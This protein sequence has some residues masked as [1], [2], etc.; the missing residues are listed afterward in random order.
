M[1]DYFC[2]T[3]AMRIDL[4]QL[5][6]S[7]SIQINLDKLILQDKTLT[8]AQI[9]NEDI[10]NINVRSFAANE[11][12]LENIIANKVKLENTNFTDVL[13]I[14]SELTAAAMS[15]ASWRRVQIKTSRCGGLQLQASDLKDVTFTGCKL[16]LVNF[17]QSKLTNV[18]FEDCILDEADFNAAELKNVYFH[19][20]LLDKAEFSNSKLSKVD[21]R[22][23]DINR[24]LGISSFAGAIIDS[25]QLTSIAPVLASE[26]N[27]DVRD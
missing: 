6:V 5:S 24:V 26:L 25:L 3:S 22:T 9:K 1:F 8:S 20:C 16:N 4:P 21:F 10:T 19:K 18:A 12:R 15:D 2:Y 13:I 23:S 17:R 27:I 14:D 7:L 11:S